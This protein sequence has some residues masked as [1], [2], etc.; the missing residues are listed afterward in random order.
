MGDDD[1]DDDGDEDD[2]QPI[3]GCPVSAAYVV[4]PEA[5][6]IRVNNNAN[7]EEARQQLSSQI[8]SSDATA[9]GTAREPAF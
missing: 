6:E 1:D 4:A 5:A 3:E 9:Q 8:G 2:P 7:V